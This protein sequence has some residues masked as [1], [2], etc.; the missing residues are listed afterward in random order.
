MNKDDF[1]DNGSFARVN[2]KIV[3]IQF[4]RSEIY[5]NTIDY[6]LNKDFLLIDPPI[7]HEYI[8]NKKSELYFLIN[9]NMYALNSSNALYLSAYATMFGRVFAISPTFRKE[10]RSDNHLTEFRMLEI[11]LLNC[12]FDKCLELLSDYI[13]SMLFSLYTMP[14][15]TTF[16][17]RFEKLYHNFH[18]DFKSYN[19]IIKQL[20]SAGYPLEYGTDLSD[21]DDKVSE[22]ITN[23]TFVIDYPFPLASW[24]AL[25]KD[26]KLAY[27]FN[28]ILPNRYGELAEGCQRN[29]NHGGFAYKFEKAGIQSLDWYVQAI[30]GCNSN[31]SGFGLGFDRL[32]RWVVG[33]NNI[34]DTVLFPRFTEKR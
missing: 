10:N 7:V 3:E 30:K 15:K 34:E 18:I 8:P 9:D 28:L 5:K 11:E 6:F 19:D 27:A 20:K 23:P 21:Y 31:R 2:K 16:Y 26:G 13:R 22:F 33:S 32:I 24:T 25:P 14:K 12:S 17:E 4:I 1:M 29:N